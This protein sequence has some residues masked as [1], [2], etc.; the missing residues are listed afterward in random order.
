MLPEICSDS[1]RNQKLNPQES[2]P[3]RDIGLENRLAGRFYARL[4]HRYCD[5]IKQLE[6]DSDFRRDNTFH[7]IRSSHLVT[8]KLGTL[9][10]ADRMLGYEF[11]VEF[12]CDEAAYGIYYGCRGLIL[13]GDHEAAIAYLENEWDLLVGEVCEVLNN[14]FE[15][16]DFGCRIKKTDNTDNRTFWQ[17]WFPLYD[18]EDVVEVAGRATKLIRNIYRMHIYEKSLSLPPLHSRKI[19]TRTDFTKDAFERVLSSRKLSQK[20]ALFERFIANAIQAEILRPDCRYEL[21]WRFINLKN[22]EVAHLIARFCAKAQLLDGDKVPWLY[23]TSNFLS[24]TNE[25]FDSI[26]KSFSA[27]KHIVSSKTD[28][29]SKHEH[30]ADALLRRIMPELY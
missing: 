1:V 19:D 6:S 25:R 3:G 2:V 9:F 7:G 15:G 22:V 28:N 4:V 8:Y 5:K 14:T 24:Y 29:F 21:C 20:R 16:K 11:L 10:S 23:F 18:D 27:S 13:G 12:D 26:K 17:F 30:T